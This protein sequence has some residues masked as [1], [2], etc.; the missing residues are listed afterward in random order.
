VTTFAEGHRVWSKTYLD[1]EPG[2][3]T[4]VDVEQGVELISVTWPAAFIPFAAP[5]TAG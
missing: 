4:R 5:R 1:P 2:T 3:V